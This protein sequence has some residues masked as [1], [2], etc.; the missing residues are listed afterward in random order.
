L[1]T[2]KQTFQQTLS[3]ENL[4]AMLEAGFINYPTTKVNAG[5]SWKSTSSV[6]INF[7]M[8]SE[9][10]WSLKS[11]E[12]TQ[13]SIESDGILTNSDVTKIM[14]LPNGLK[15]KTDLSG[16]QVTKSKVDVK[17]GWPVET[18]V[19]SEIKGTLTLL[20]GSM[21]PSD[22]EVPMEIITESTFTII[23]K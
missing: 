4:K 2:T 7:A 10:T 13:A 8:K 23:K 21:L 18:K 6:A 3:E 9:N 5:A 20:A 11:I 16:K 19:L 12:G 17:N 15:A 1:A 14:A 22:M